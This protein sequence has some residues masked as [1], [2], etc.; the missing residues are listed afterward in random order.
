MKEIKITKV[1]LDLNRESKRK[2]LF[3][4]RTLDSKDFVLDDTE[5]NENGDP[6]HRI[7]YRYSEHETLLEKIEYDASDDLIERHIFIE[8]EPEI[9]NETIIE[10]GNGSKITKKFRD[11]DLGKGYQ[12]TVT[13]ENGIVL[14]Y[15][16]YVFDDQ[17]RIV[18]EIESNEM[19]EEVFRIDR[20]YDASGK[21]T[22]E[23]QFSDGAM[24]GVTRNYYNAEGD[25][26]EI[27]IGPDEETISTKQLFELDAKKRIV[28]RMRHFLD[29]G[30]EEIEHYAYDENDN[31]ISNH[32]VQ[33]GRT[34]FI[35]LC[36]YDDKNRL[37]EEY[38]MEISIRG[39]IR[40]HERLFYDYED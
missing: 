15:E 35:N 18:S 40:K 34:I 30:E 32:F 26:I 4:T 10:Y 29:S 37:K 22:S 7:T 20:M 5:F 6:V 28:K 19:L 25:L 17:K 14:G 11:T 8:T 31:L 13:D 2:F 9:V 12:G 24:D 39:K 33:N 36:K 3:K 23:I 21:I 27:Q 16:T 38:V 1:E